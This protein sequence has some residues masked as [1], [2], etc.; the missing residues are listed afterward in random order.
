MSA[1]TK[2]RL[3]LAAFFCALSLLA[4]SPGRALTDTEKAALQNAVENFTGAM[5]RNDFPTIVASS[6]PPRLLQLIAGKGD[7]PPDALR[8]SIVA[9]TEQIMSV[10]KIESFSFDFAAAQFK[11]LPGGAPYVL[12]PTVTN[13]AVQGRQ[14]TGKDQTLAFVE[15]GKW[16]LLRVANAQQSSMIRE[17]YPEYQNVDFPLGTMEIDNK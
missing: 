12:I 14:V 6:I 2:G 13:M 4:P 8:K 1:L 17:A 15:D 3:W 7:V 10:V 5:R 11:E 16:Y 9:Q